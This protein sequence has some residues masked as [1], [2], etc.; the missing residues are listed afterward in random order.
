MSVHVQYR[1]ETTQ[2]SIAI[3]DSYTDTSLSCGEFNLKAVVDVLRASHAELCNSFRH[4]AVDLCAEIF[5]KKLLSAAVYGMVLESPAK[6]I[7]TA[8]LECANNIA[9]VGRGYYD[10]SK[11]DDFLNILGKDPVFAPIAEK[12]RNG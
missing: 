7:N 8:L 11:L 6:Y 1:K 3:S 12:L 10:P 4:N 5:S 2:L 9:N